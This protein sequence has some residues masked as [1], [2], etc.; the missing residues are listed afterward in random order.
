MT[1]I[2]L[3][4]YAPEDCGL[5]AELFRRSVREVARRDYSEVQVRAWAPDTADLDRWHA[6]LTAAETWTA[7]VGDR[8]AGFADLEADGHLDHFFVHPD[9][10]RIGVA[11]ALYGEI[12]RAAQRMGLARIYAE[13]SLTARPAFERF[14]FT[15]IAAQTVHV[16]GQDFVNFRM[17][18]RLDAKAGALDA[19][20][21]RP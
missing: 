19:A 1:T 6:R 10:Q 2:D 12:E 15:L 5:V 18:R 17:A 9:F 8:L 14:G 16:R 3:R 21:G 7:W 20:T 11:T 13:V 4:P